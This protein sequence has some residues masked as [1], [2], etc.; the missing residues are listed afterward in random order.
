MFGNPLKPSRSTVFHGLSAEAVLGTFTSSLTNARAAVLTRVLFRKTG[1]GWTLASQLLPDMD[2]CYS[3]LEN[4]SSALTSELVSVAGKVRRMSHEEYISQYSGGKRKIYEA[5]SISVRQS[6]ICQK[7]AKIKGFIKVEKDIRSD[8]PSRIPRV[9]SPP[10]ARYRLET[11]TFVKPAEHEIY[12][13]IDKI[14]GFKAVTKGLNYDQVAHLFESGWNSF[15]DP[16]GFDLDVKRMDQATSWGIPFTN[17]FICELFSG[18]ENLYAEWLLEMQQKYKVTIVAKDG[19]ISYECATSL[20]SGQTN[21]SLVGVLQ[22]NAMVWAF[23]DAH[24]LRIRYV[25]A[26]D[27]MSIICERKDVDF[28]KKNI[29]PWFVQFGMELEIG[30]I[31]YRLEH[32]EFCQTRPILI[33][34]VWRMVRNPRTVSIKDACSLKHLKSPKMRYAHL[35]SVGT[36][37]LACF[38][39]IPILEEFYA[40]LVREADRLILD[41]KLTLRQRKSWNASYAKIERE[42]GS[43]KWWGHGMNHERG[44][45]D[46]M[47]RVSFMEGFGIT[48]TE[49]L[50]IETTYRNWRLL[51]DEVPLESNQHVLL[52]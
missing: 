43:I 1:R 16:V 47:T 33:G 45:I 50:L 31:A 18:D 4:F 44:G 11:G 8:K 35:K 52:F 49:Q 46:P 7:D 24:A 32:M 20:T 42:D 15:I 41:S 21:T 30:Q 51:P 27:D 2:A 10:S 14:W 38:S 9:I 13:A 37:G 12:S 25:N 40:A 23:C 5:A 17:Y 19:L 3:L 39:G 34:G 6:P 36:G 29:G 26:G 28:I 48:P 22:V